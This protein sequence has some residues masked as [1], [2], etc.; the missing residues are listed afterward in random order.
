MLKIYFGH[1]EDELSI[2]DGWFDNQLSDEYYCTE[3]SKRVIKEI[4]NSEVV[5]ENM[6]LSLVL[7]GIPITDI[8]SG[9]KGLIVMK[10]TDK[11]VNLVSLGDNCIPLLLEILAE[12]DERCLV[13][14]RFVSLYRYGWKKPILVLNN[15][16]VV[17]NHIELIK[18]YSDI[19]SEG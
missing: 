9:A 7:G 18:A 4:D 11:A 3:F 16:T 17:N 2:A 19:S 13:S 12:D 1:T 5:N 6:V 10:Y 14:A 15:N 8:S